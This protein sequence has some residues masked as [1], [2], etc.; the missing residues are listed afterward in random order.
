MKRNSFIRRGSVSLLLS[1]M[2]AFCSFPV[3]AAVTLAQALDEPA[4][5]TD[6]A[7]SET[8]V[9]PEQADSGSYEAAFA[10]STGND[11]EDT[12]QMLAAALQEASADLAGIKSTG[13]SGHNKPVKST[14]KQKAQRV[15]RVQIVQ[16]A[17]ER[18]RRPDGWQA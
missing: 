12:T 10:Y 3:T 14:E 7:E 2:L 1:G 15:Q 11:A 13:S 6:T 9:L 17:R 18:R 5:E 8:Q 4:E 16:K